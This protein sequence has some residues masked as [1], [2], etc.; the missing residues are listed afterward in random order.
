MGRDVV[1]R[2]AALAGGIEQ[3][4]AEQLVSRRLRTWQR[5]AAFGGLRLKHVDH[6]CVLLNRPTRPPSLA[7]KYALTQQIRR[8]TYSIPLNIAEGSGKYTDKDFTRYL[9]NA[10]GSAKEVE[11]ALLLIVDLEYIQRDVFTNLNKSINEIIAMLIS[12][13]NYLRKVS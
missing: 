8:A 2:R 4:H 1:E 12:F 10:L 9:D 5:D 3:P 13:I 7:E 11:Y 6:A